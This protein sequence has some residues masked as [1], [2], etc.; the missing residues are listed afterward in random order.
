MVH[1]TRRER[2]SAGALIRRFTRRVQR[3]GIILQARKGQFFRPKPNRAER[4]RAAQRR[5]EISQE[6]EELWKLGKLDDEQF[7]PK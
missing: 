5:A 7:T 2:E 4:R 6:R 1:V 3:A